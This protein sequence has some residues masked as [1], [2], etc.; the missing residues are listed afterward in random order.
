LTKTIIPVNGERLRVYFNPARH[1]KSD[2]FS[3]RL[4]LAVCLTL[5]NLSLANQIY[6]VPHVLPDFTMRALPSYRPEPFGTKNKISKICSST[7]Q[8]NPKRCREKKH[9]TAHLL[10]QHRC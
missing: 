6:L 8:E 9:D 2:H 7:Y 10:F 3:Q 5:T 1:L 4:D